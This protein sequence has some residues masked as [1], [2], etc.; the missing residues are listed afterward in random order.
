VGGHVSAGEDFDDTVVREAGEELWDDGRSGRVHLAPDPQAFADAVRAVDLAQAAVL[1]RHSLQR[2]LRDVRHAPDRAGV[3]NVI[4][5]VAIYLG[6]TDVAISDF[7]PQADEIAGLRYADAAEVDRLLLQ[8]E[9]APNMAFLWLTH[10][11]AL[12]ALAGR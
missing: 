9:L 5:H 4:Y 2:G 12:L 6:R 3:R 11:R 1:A 7:R 8:G 10:A